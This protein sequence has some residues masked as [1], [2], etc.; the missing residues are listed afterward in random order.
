[1][2]RIP[3]LRRASLFCGVFLNRRSA[4]FDLALAGAAAAI[5]VGS[6][7]PAAVAIPYLYYLARSAI[8]W[9][10]WAP[11]VLP[12]HVAS[13]AVG[14]AALIWGSVRTRALVL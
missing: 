11:I 13:D 6:V 2:A 4:A 7:V 9:R 5:L 12:A 3:E 14:L 1:V 8:G 10:R